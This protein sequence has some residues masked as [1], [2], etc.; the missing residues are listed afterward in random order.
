LWDELAREQAE[1]RTQSFRKWR[2]LGLSVMKVR[3]VAVVMSGAADDVSCVVFHYECP[4][5]RATCAVVN[6]L[7]LL[8]LLLLLREQKMVRITLL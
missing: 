2:L 8:L 7:L 5:L 4:G 1:V 6:C 3:P